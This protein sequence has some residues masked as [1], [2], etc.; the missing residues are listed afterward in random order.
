MNDIKIFDPLYGIIF[1]PNFVWKI[2]LTPE[3]QRLR[4]VRLLNINS[5]CFIGGANINR[6]EHSIGTCYL[7]LQC[8]KTMSLNNKFTKDDERIF[9]LA[10]LMHDIASSA[11]G[12]TY[13]YIAPK[14]GSN[15]EKNFEEVILGKKGETFYTKYSSFE[16]IF[17]GLQREISSILNIDEIKEISKNVTGSGKFGVLI[18]NCIDLDNI[19]NVYRA[20]YHI[21][22]NQSGK[23]PLKLA[24]SIWVKDNKLF[25]KNDAEE[26]IKK[27]FH[28]R[29]KLYT[30]LFFNKEEFSSKCML[31]EAIEIAKK[32]LSCRDPNSIK[33]FDVDF[34]LLLKLKSVSVETDEII[35]RIMKGNLFGCIGIYVTP[36]IS[37]YNLLNDYDKKIEIENEINIVI[38]SQKISYLKSAMVSLYP[39]ID[40]NKIER[41]ITI[42][43][44][45]YKPL[46]IG[47]SSKK[48]LI[49]I[50]F[51]NVGLNIFDIYKI[52]EN[53]L[54]KIQDKILEKFI[55]IFK[56]NSITKFDNYTDFEG[57]DY[58]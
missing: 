50:F 15:H 41:Q 47:N 38:R 51:K 4:E 18:N 36:N 8:F 35:T 23:E 25:I 5:L 48:L 42:F 19:D 34:E 58:N 6:Y 17:F 29:K 53:I 43:N 27:W 31:S 56:T 57:D 21:G 28:L 44:E 49:G 9:L 1:L 12:H 10:A 55:D 52:D 2:I 45:N 37:I 26:L 40:N 13:E 32:R 22:F 46:D 14:K 24:T 7:A 54:R 20:S 33:W 3:I 11:F 30:Y 39:A 16:T